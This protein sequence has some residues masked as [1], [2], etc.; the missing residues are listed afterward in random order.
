MT[1]STQVLGIAAIFVLVASSGQA[2]NQPPALEPGIDCPLVVRAY[3]A[4][5]AQVGGVSGMVF[6]IR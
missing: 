1:R 3:F 2:G 6:L 4:E 5:R